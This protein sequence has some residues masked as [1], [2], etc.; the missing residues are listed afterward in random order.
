MVSNDNTISYEVE[1]FSSD[2]HNKIQQLARDVKHKLKNTFT[3]RQYTPLTFYEFHMIDHLYKLFNT[4][5]L[6]TIAQYISYDGY[7]QNYLNILIFSKE[8]VRA[9]EVEQEL[10]GYTVRQLETLIKEVKS[11]TFA[12]K[13]KRK[14]ELYTE[15]QCNI[16]LMILT[17]KIMEKRYTPYVRRV[18]K[19]I[20]NQLSTDNFMNTMETL[21]FLEN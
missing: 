14:E 19:R 21:R 4:T 9:E 10:K 13:N 17:F 3:N 2:K 15:I 7:I 18:I 8:V 12:G 1:N 20:F 16:L 6:K 11:T 5:P